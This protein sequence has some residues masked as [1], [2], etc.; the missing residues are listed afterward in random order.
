MSS[1]T[2]ATNGTRAE[3]R[4]SLCEIDSAVSAV[5]GLVALGQ[6]IESARSIIDSLES[7]RRIYKDLDEKFR[8]HDILCGLDWNE[9][10][11]AGLCVLLSKVYGAASTLKVEQP[12]RGAHV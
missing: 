4:P 2:Q 11:S 8:E 6:W 12:A 9:E 7:S 3:P 10:E 1:L 5:L